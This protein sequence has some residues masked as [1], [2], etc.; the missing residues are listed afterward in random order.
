MA[1]E[2]PSARA[3]FVP[4]PTLAVAVTLA[5]AALCWA[6]VV[7]QAGSMGSMGMG[8]GSLPSFM[9]TWTV[10]MA[11]MML[12]SA[13][14]FIRA[15]AGLPGRNPWPIDSGLL[16]A[17][18]LAV[19]ALFGLGAYYVYSALGML[20]PS[21]DRSLGVALGIASLYALTP[22]KQ[23]FGVG[24]RS[25]CSRLTARVATEAI[26]RGVTYGLNCVGCSAGVMVVMLVAG[27]SNLVWM[28]V[29]TAIA[30]LYKVVLRNRRQNSVIALITLVVGIWLA[31][32][33]AS[34]PMLLMP[35]AHA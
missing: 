5:T 27:M 8:L 31:A 34:V 2:S 23:R 24:C 6:V 35:G 22:M 29:V 13:L 21:S 17:A 1:A 14:P 4:A 10:M 16:V 9:G 28:V 15:Y 11:A 33:P 18:Y 12:P 30:L 3:G 7:S 26:T 20:W 25:I 32:F 19:W